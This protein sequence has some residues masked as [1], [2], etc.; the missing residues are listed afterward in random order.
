[1]PFQDSAV[2]ESINCTFNS[3]E[4]KDHQ[5]PDHHQLCECYNVP[6]VVDDVDDTLRMI[7]GDIDTPCG[8]SPR[9][10]ASSEANAFQLAASN[11]GDQI[12][13]I[14]SAIRLTEGLEAVSLMISY[15]YFETVYF[16]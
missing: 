14:L 13:K 8:T 12:A 4:E 11:D 2:F 15:S 1:M 9:P 7:Q 3:Y 10:L 16:L 6:D 5:T